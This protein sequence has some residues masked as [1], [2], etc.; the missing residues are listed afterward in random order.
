VEVIPLF[1][2]LEMAPP[3]AIMGL[4]DAFNQDTNPDKINLT[5]GVY[6]NESGTTPIFRTVKTAEERLLS[7]E[8]TKSYLSIDGSREYAAAV[9]DLIF[10]ADHE[11]VS[12]KR[13]ATAHTPGGT[14]ALRVAA[15]FIKRINPESKVWLS[16]PTWPNHPDIFKAAGLETTN[17]PYY[18]AESK[19]LDFDAM[20]A[21]LADVQPGDTVLLHGCCHNPTGMDP[22]AEQ[23][24]QLAELLGSKKA[25][26]FFDFAYQGLANGLEEDAVGLRTFCTEGC[27][28]LV[29]SSF[30][31]NFG[32]YRERTGA[33]TLVASSSDAAAKSMSILKQV[34]RANYSNPPSHGAAI[35]TTI[36]GDAELRA[37]WES[38]VK[39]MC[40][41]IASMRQQFVDK[42][43][44][45]GVTRDFSF[46]TTQNGMFSF[47]GLNPAQVERLR[48]EYSIYIVGSGRINVASLTPGNIDA[49]CKAVSEVL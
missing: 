2:A 25:L 19:T 22:D 15:E 27:E 46:L 38:E 3:D 48:S 18:D 29:S 36:L 35:V 7:E 13:A 40:A 10:G 6:K 34:I 4:T 28:L 21:A 9:Q 30:S 11:I 1:D 32:L 42:L 23:W 12:S 43:K 45:L 24:Q 17:Y 39:E 41:R 33:L 47:S 5:I 49:F 16:Q 37:D 44:A 20:T 8:T 14:G 26:V 31:K